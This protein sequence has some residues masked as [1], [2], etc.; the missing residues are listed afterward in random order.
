[1]RP[2]RQKIKKIILSGGGTGG[3]VTPL[4]AVARELITEEAREREID[5]NQVQSW[6]FVFV[7]TSNGPEQ[8]LV[9]AFDHLGQKIKFVTIPAGK[10]RRYFSWQNLIDIFRIFQ[11]FFVSYFLLKKEKPDLFFSAG[12]FVGVPLAWAAYF[13]NIPIIIHQQDVRPGL[14]NRLV[15]PLARLI[16]VTFEK[17]LKDYG[18]RAVWTGNPSRQT[19]EDPGLFLGIKHKFNLNLNKPLLV[20]TGGG[21][22]SK[23]INDLAISSAHKLSAVFQVVHLSGLKKEI[24]EAKKI[25]DFPADYQVFEFIANED[26][27]LLLGAA[28]LVVTRCGLATLTELSALAKPAIL[29]PMPNSHQEENAAVF[30]QAKAA[31][32]LNQAKLNSDIFYATI[33]NLLADEERRKKLSQNISRLMKRDATALIASFIKEIN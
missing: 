28:D 16:T 23:A 8:K 7:G 17:S 14:A 20:I 6:E 2:S 32:V 22:G 33:I 19:P 26:A 12:G 30:A 29:I 27:F 3:S 5:L 15:A 9:E 31:V 10:F 4:L 11:A 1:M 25:I 18:S 21:T 24:N 13:L